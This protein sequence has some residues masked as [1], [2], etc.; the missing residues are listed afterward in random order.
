MGG[1]IEQS[2]WRARSLKKTDMPLVSEIPLLG[3]YPEDV[4]GE[5]S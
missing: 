3:D 2:F 1:H 5:V 4:V